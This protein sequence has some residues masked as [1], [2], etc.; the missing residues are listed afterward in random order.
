[1]SEKLP[2]KGTT[3][4]QRQL[5]EGGAQP[6][7]STLGRLTMS[8]RSSPCHSNSSQRNDKNSLMNRMHSQAF[9]RESGKCQEPVIVLCKGGI[10]SREQE[11]PV[12]SKTSSA[13]GA[14]NR[15][16]PKARGFTRPPRGKR[17]SLPTNYTVSSNVSALQRTT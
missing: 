9:D 12:F 11:N 10:K 7:H 1:M 16:T 4:P 17:V 14:R 13:G 8:R 3:Q 6:Q 2:F 5:T 15:P